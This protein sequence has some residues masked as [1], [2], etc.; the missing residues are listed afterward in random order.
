MVVVHNCTTLQ[1]PPLGQGPSLR[2]GI[3]RPA[4]VFVGERVPTSVG[5][6]SDPE[7]D[8]V[9]VAGRYW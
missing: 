2:H 8:P 3:L 9:E 1:E 7:G 5:R 4:V 6:R